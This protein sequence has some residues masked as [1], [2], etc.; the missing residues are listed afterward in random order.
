VE[1]GLQRRLRGE[2]ERRWAGKA[3]LRDISATKQPDQ[4]TAKLMQHSSSAQHVKSVD[5]RSERDGTWFLI[6]L[7][8][9]NVTS[10]QVNDGQPPT[11]TFV[12]AFAEVEY[13]SSEKAK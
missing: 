12:L 5:L 2:R 6:K 3:K 4:H 13:E 7:K 8:D 11:E 9:V 10:F 1:L